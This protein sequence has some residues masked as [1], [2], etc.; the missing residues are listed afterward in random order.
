MTEYAHPNRWVVIH[1]STEEDVGPAPQISEGD[2]DDDF[3]C[4]SRQVAYL[5]VSI[6]EPANSH[7]QMEL[8]PYAGELHFG[9]GNMFEFDLLPQRVMGEFGQHEFDHEVERF[10][11]CE[12]V[13]MPLL[14]HAGHR[15]YDIQVEG[16]EM[17]T[18]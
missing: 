5:R 13:C 14:P 17:R 2:V 4:P 6:V 3:I 7:G 9:L 16:G 10:Q 12:S 11:R 8:Q 15:I 18:Y 1:A